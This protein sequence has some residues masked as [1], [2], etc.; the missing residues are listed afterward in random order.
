MRLALSVLAAVVALAGNARAESRPARPSGFL[1]Q[2][3]AGAQPLARDLAAHAD[4]DRAQLTA[5]LGRDYDGTTTVRVTAE[6]AGF[7]SALPTG[8]AVPWWAV[9][10]A[11][12]DLNLIVIRAPT[13]GQSARAVF[14]HELSHIAVGRLTRGVMPRW[15]LEGL[16]TM[17]AGDLWSRQGPSLV[18]AGLADNLLPFDQLR[19]SF[20]KGSTDSELAYAQS[21]AFMQFLADR[22]GEA[23]L[24]DV[25]RQVVNGSTFD[26]AMIRVF[27]A[28]PRQLENA[29]RRSLAK[30]ILLVDFVTSRDLIWMVLTVLL[31]YAGWHARR[32]RRARMVLLE[33]EE[34][35]EAARALLRAPGL[36]ADGPRGPPAVA[37]APDLIGGERTVPVESS[38]EAEDDPQ[39]K[40]PTL[41]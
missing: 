39:P 26:D 6:E 35:A 33:R 9:A 8:A 13:G 1:F 3:G 29:W 2:S 27:G 19:T 16:A 11:F 4:E 14:R 23:G 37:V 12:P 41:H 30:W 31:A 34:Q 17:Q 21:A 7:K 24:D 20:P 15:F 40:K 5:E 32:R 18:Q 36:W 22:K 25:I 38:S 10:V 28:G